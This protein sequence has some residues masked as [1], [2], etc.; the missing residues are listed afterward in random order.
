MRRGPERARGGRLL[1]PIRGLRDH[2]A[3]STA[4][5]APWPRKGTI[6]TLFTYHMLKV[7]PPQSQKHQQDLQD[8]YF[9]EY[10]FTMSIF[11]LIHKSIPSYLYRN[12]CAQKRVPLFPLKWRKSK[13]SSSPGGPSAGKRKPT[14]T[15]VTT[16]ATIKRPSASFSSAS[17]GRR[18]RA[19]RSSSA[20]KSRNGFE[21][22]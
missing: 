22:Q 8:E 17:L 12:L 19:S 18:S 13:W 4:T 16:T 7:F 14:I 20:D 15:S 3:T 5:A 11:F 21:I 9:R 6:D 1:A 2:R 10:I